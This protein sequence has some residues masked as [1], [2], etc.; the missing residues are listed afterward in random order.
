MKIKEFNKIKNYSG[1]INHW[2]EEIKNGTI[3]DAFAYAAILSTFRH[4][5]NLAAARYVMEEIRSRN[6]L[7]SPIGN[8]MLDLYCRLKDYESAEDLFKTMQRFQVEIQPFGINSLI[9]AFSQESVDKSIDFITFAYES[10]FE[11]DS[12]NIDL[13]IKRSSYIKDANSLKRIYEIIQKAKP[14]LTPEI[15]NHLIISY[16][17]LIS[18]TEALKVADWIS[19]NTNMGYYAYNTLLTHYTYKNDFKNGLYVE[20]KIKSQIISPTAHNKTNILKNLLNLRINNGR[21]DEALNLV[22]EI[23]E[24]HPDSVQYLQDKIGIV[25]LLNGDLANSKEILFQ[26][27]KFSI[28]SLHQVLEIYIDLK[29]Y[30]HAEELMDMAIQHSSPTIFSF[31]KIIKMYTLLDNEEKAMKWFNLIKKSGTLKP[32]KE[33]YLNIIDMYKRLGNQDSVQKLTNEMQ[34]NFKIFAK[35]I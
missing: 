30:D 17:S 33:T 5:N 23:E 26:H 20:E 15:I 22:K 21:Y 27:D 32:T 24:I 25:Y 29:E 14:T 18:D 6:I 28:H 35:N 8:Q 13:I 1:A 12:S 4:D 31:N 34:Q 16:G 9:R 2:N 3:P 7:T 11:I 19:E 10:G